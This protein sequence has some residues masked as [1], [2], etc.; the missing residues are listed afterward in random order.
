L[1]ISFILFKTIDCI[2]IS[3]KSNQ[4]K[5]LCNNLMAK[6]GGR[7]GVKERGKEGEGVRGMAPPL[8]SQNAMFNVIQGVCQST[9]VIRSNLPEPTDI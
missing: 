1:A 7:E 2:L 4:K 5:K 9:N 3:D 6:V 8:T